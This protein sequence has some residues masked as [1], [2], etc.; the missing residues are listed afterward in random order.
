VLR[1]GAAGA[2]DLTL[3]F[4]RS[5]KELLGGVQKM[6]LRSAKS[7]LWIVWAKKTS[8]LAGDVTETEVRGAGLAAGMVDFKIC[9]VDQDWSGLRFN[10]RDRR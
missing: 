3:W 7:G 8:Q 5:Q 2:A 4:V 1:R 10:L 6:A 9:A